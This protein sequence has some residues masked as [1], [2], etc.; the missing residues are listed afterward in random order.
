MSD[1]LPHGSPTALT[2]AHCSA[3]PR[4][5][6]PP[7]PTIMVARFGL[8]TTA[9]SGAPT[10]SPS[11][12]TQM[13]AIVLSVDI[14]TLGGLPVPLY[15]SPRTGFTINSAVH[16]FAPMTSM[17]A[18]GSP[19][20]SYLRV[21]R[22]GPAGPRCRPPLKRRRPAI[23]GLGHQTIRRLFH[24]RGTSFGEEVSPAGCLRNLTRKVFGP[25]RRFL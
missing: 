24:G 16:P 25:H 5:T 6:A 21:F 2:R 1:G 3:A 19:D 23:A 12:S 13:S 11:G 18:A 4:P 14:A 22:P 8:S 9:D 7:Q 17:N 10:V 20:R 15:P